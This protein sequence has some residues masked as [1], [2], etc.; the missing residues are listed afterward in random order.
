M[1]AFARGRQRSCGPPGSTVAA[2]AA[3]T[4][5]SCRARAGPGHTTGAAV[6]PGAAIPGRCANGCAAIAART[7]YAAGTAGASAGIDAC[8]SAG[9][10]DA[11]R[12]A[13]A[14][15]EAGIARAAQWSEAIAARSTGSSC[16]AGAGGEAC[17]SR[18]AGSAGTANA[19]RPWVADAKHNA[20]VSA[21]ATLAALS[22]G[23]ASLGRRVASC[24]TLSAVAPSTPGAVGTECANS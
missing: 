13:H 1:A 5:S 10:A 17:C 12:A 3:V 7:A 20:S 6:S 16:A 11:T 8:G 9:P 21:P 24:A 22:A 23:V 4:G 18:A 19:A 14:A 2:L 15:C